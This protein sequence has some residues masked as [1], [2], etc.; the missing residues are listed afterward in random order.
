[1]GMAGEG[2][3][4]AGADVAALQATR[5]NLMV[6]EPGAQIVEQRH[7]LHRLQTIEPDIF[8]QHP[9]IMAES[10]D[11]FV[12]G[13]RQKAGIAGFKIHAARGQHG[14]G[15]A[16]E[17][18]DIGRQKGIDAGTDQDLELVQ[19]LE[20]GGV[21][22]DGAD[23]DDFLELTR[24]QPMVGHGTFPGGEFQIEDRDRARAQ[25]R[26]GAGR[27]RGDVLHDCHGTTN[28]SKCAALTHC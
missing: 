13:E 16:G 1:M 5:V 26:G 19:D 15:D 10:A 12:A 28:H 6:R 22:A 11:R 2:H 17:V 7:V 23:Q 4:Q 8:F 21:Q 25:R 27:R 20:G 18:F 3:A 14:A 24:A 9:F